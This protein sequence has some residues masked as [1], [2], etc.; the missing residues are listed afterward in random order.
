VTRGY[1]APRGEIEETLA[2]LWSELLKVE[3]VGRNDSFFELGGHSLLAVQLMN[4]VRRTFDVTMALRLLFQHPTV[5]A[6]ADDIVEATLAQFDP[7][8][9]EKLL[10]R[11]DTDS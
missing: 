3:R 7:E 6:F 1:E 9:L 4:K 8:S 2:R 10:S 5:A 11:G